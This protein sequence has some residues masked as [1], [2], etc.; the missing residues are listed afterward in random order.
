VLDVGSYL[1]NFSLLAA[2]SGYEVHALDTYDE[3][4]SCTSGVTELLKSAGIRIIQPTTS[5]NYLADLADSSFDAVMFLG[6]IEHIPHSPKAL[7]LEILRVLRP[8]GVLVMDTPNQAYIFNRW[9]LAEGQSIYGPLSSQFHT[10]PPFEGHHREFTIEETEWMLHE[11][12][13]VDLITET[14]NYSLYGLSEFS[15]DTLRGILITEDDWTSREVIMC[16]ALKP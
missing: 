1:G 3:F 13:F 12:G 6:V 8:G 9:R 7:L 2:R 15:G 5:V 11:V 14:F 16:S 10:P 4:G